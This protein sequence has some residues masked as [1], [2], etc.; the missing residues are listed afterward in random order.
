MQRQR[1]NLAD[2]TVQQLVDYLVATQSEHRKPISHLDKSVDKLVREDSASLR[3][4]AVLIPVT[5]SEPNQASQ[6]I[7]TVRSDNLTS[8]PG[9]ISLPGGTR[10]EHD[11]NDIET[12]LRESEEEIGLK[13]ENVEVLGQLGDIALPS[14]FCVTPVVGLVEPGLTLTPCPI[15]VADIFHVPLKLMLNPSSYSSSTMLFEQTP[16]K[17]LELNYKK[18]RIWGATAA[19]LYH[20]A[21]EVESFGNSELGL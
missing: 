15:E 13:P 17:I 4:A 6:I 11:D 3:K 5:R 9:Q 1:N 16:R 10:E 19:I 20:L 21:K 2:P 8:H 14:G 12:A 7:L 18:Y